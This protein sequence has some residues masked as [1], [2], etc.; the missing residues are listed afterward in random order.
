MVQPFLLGAPNASQPDSPHSCH[1]TASAPPSTK[2]PSRST[3]VMFRRPL[4]SSQIQF[5]RNTNEMRSRSF[6]RSLDLRETHRAVRRRPF[7]S[8][9]HSSQCNV[10]LGLRQQFAAATRALDS[11]VTQ[12]IPAHHE[13]A[14]TLLPAQVW[15]QLAPTPQPSLWLQ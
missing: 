4:V 7:S 3:A 8:L 6:A 2:T 14:Y 1:R 12:P 10:Q 11:R 13:C 9:C 5:M 15:A